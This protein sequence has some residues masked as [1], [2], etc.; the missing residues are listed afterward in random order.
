MKRTMTQAE[1]VAYVR[2]WRMVQAAEHA[3]LRRASPELKL[4]QLAALMASVDWLGLRQALAE[5]EDEVRDR[6]RRL[7]SCYGV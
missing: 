6:W 5:E 7:R 1:A 2:R 3:E 4:R